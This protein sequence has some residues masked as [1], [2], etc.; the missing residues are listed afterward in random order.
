MLVCDPSEAARTGEVVIRSRGSHTVRRGFWKLRSERSEV[1]ISDQLT[2]LLGR[3]TD[4][5]TVWHTLAERYEIDLFCG[6]F[7]AARNRGI[8]LHPALLRQLADRHITIGFDI[9]GP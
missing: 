8:E 3:L 4:D 9:Y 5:L 2:V 7:L 1:D 6:L